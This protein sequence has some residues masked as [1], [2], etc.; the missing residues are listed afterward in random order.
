MKIADVLPLYKSKSP[1]ETTNY[2]PIS[3]L[4]TISKILEKVI[5]KRIYTFLTTIIN[6]MTVNMASK[7]SIP[8]RMLSMNY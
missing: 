6:Y 5:Y 4:L 3:L 2:R 8:V 7:P 1:L